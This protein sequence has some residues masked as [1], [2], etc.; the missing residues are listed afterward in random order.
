VASIV[1]FGRALS[2]ARACSNLGRKPDPLTC[3]V[4]GSAA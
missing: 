3:E 1:F 4:G 2:A